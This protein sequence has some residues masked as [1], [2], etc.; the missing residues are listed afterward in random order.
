MTLLNAK[1]VPRKLFD[2][3][4]LGCKLSKD[5][6]CH[7]RPIIL[8]YSNVKIILLWKW[9]SF[10]NKFQKAVTSF[11]NEVFFLPQTVFGVFKQSRRQLLCISTSKRVLRMLVE[12][13][14][15]ML[16]QFFTSFSVRI[17]QKITKTY[18]KRVSTSI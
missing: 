18:Y 4:T 5:H 17:T 11:L 2:H 10:V 16:K 3:S 7:E 15:L 6:P 13:N 1:L 9:V 14:F 8:L 12:I